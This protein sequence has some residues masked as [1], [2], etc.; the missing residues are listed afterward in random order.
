[1]RRIDWDSPLSA[2]DETWLRMVSLPGCEAMIAENR[3]R[4]SDTG[5]AEGDIT[6]DP[7]P[8]DYDEWT[9]SELDDEIGK[10][11]KLAP[12]TVVGTGKNGNVL[13]TD[14]VKALRLWD[15]E[16]TEN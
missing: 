1:M 9:R 2:E 10:R 4:F 8:D 7:E 11:E 6:P 15:A 3:L 5:E 12:V 13:V 16:N 14:L